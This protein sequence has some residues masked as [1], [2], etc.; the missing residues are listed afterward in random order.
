MNPS[1]SR[2]GIVVAAAALVVLSGAWRAYSLY[3]RPQ[4]L[5]CPATGSDAA[6]TVA[7]E[8]DKGVVP[9]VVTSTSNSHRLPSTQKPTGS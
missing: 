6:V 2:R 8:S 4:L 3:C 7:P 9:L 1:L 5:H